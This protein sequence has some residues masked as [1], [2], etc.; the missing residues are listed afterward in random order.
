MTEKEWYRGFGGG[1]EFGHCPVDQDRT[2][3]ID[4]N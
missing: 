3:L 1:E 4:C 2:R